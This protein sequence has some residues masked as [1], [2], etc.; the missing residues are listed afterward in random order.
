MLVGKIHFTG[1]PAENAFLS[2]AVPWSAPTAEDRERG[3]GALFRARLPH[4]LRTTE[5]V[6]GREQ[7][8][9]AEQQFELVGHILLNLERG[10]TTPVL[11]EK[12]RQTQ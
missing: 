11:I 12:I 6:G 2:E 8:S 3:V 7:Y 10:A 5:W 1:N 9:R 4:R